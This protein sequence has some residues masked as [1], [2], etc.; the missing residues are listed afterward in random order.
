LPQSGAVDLAV[1]SITGQR[2]RTLMQGPNTAGE[3][4]IRWDGLSDRGAAVPPGAYLVR[5]QSREERARRLLIW[6]GR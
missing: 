2:L 1:F 5:L 4:T 3:H 6:L